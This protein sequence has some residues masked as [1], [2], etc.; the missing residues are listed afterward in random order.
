MGQQREAE[1]QGQART[2][3]DP[4]RATEEDECRRDG[5]DDRER[6]RMRDRAVRDG[7]SEII[8]IG[9]G[10]AGRSDEAH[11]SRRWSLLGPGSDCKTNGRV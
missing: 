1:N 2:L 5:A 4:L 11:V 8:D 3:L 6:E 9:Q 7:P 10:G